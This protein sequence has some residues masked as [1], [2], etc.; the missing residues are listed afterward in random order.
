MLH[1]QV[2]QGLGQTRAAA[3]DYDRFKATP[4]AVTTEGKM[5]A[6]DYLMAAGRYAEAADCFSVLDAFTAEN[7]IDISLDWLGVK[8]FPKLRANIQAGRV[9]SALFVAGQIAAGDFCN[10]DTTEK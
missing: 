1:I 5:K 7:E 9:D 8:F 3:R 2:E 6:V 4:Y 10:E